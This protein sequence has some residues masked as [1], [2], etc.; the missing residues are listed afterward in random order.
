MEP[1]QDLD[2][3]EGE[4]IYENKNIGEWI[5]LW[6]AST[7]AIFVSAPV[8]YTY[9]I[10]CADGIPSLSWASDTWMTWDIPR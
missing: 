6:K 10:Y 3:E 2:F 9:E 4:V 8:F 7:M 5:K 1:D